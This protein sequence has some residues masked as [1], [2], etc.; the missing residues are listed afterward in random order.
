M[1]LSELIRTHKGRRSYADIEKDC[2]GYPSAK[3][4]QQLATQPLKNFPDPP[5]IQALARGLRVPEVTLVLA[6]AET[7]GLDVHRGQARLLDLLPPDIETLTDDQVRI[8]TDTARSF[9]E[10]NLDVS[11]ARSLVRDVIA[12][13]EVQFELPAGVE[14]TREEAAEL[15]VEAVVGGQRRTQN[16]FAFFESFRN[17]K[18]EPGDG[19]VLSAID[20]K[21]RV[22][23][24]EG[25]GGDGETPAEKSAFVKAAKHGTKEPYDEPQ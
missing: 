16:S 12:R 25:G 10:S 14:A 8:L 13:D 18:L 9:L 4:I 19:L 11:F 22:L 2:G 5:T 6:V 23:K 1:N 15:F 7:L 24:Q 17:L 21:A 20:G 3:R